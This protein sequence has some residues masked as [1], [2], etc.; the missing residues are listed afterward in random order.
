ME[1]RPLV[2]ILVTKRN[3][4][5]KTL[6]LYQKYHDLNLRLFAF[7]PADIQWKAQRIIGMTR[8]KDRWVERTFPFPNAVYNRSF[9]KKK[10]TVRRL[11]RSIGRNKC[12][13]A[14]NYFN[15][16]ELHDLLKQS[17]LHSYV[18]DTSLLNQENIL[19]MINKYRLVYIKPLYGSK[20]TSVHRVELK[21]NGDIHISLHSL[22]PKYIYRKEEHSRQRMEDL[23][24]GKKYV[25]Q[26]GIRMKPLNQCVF[27]IRVLVQKGRI[28]EWTV[29]AVTCRVAYEHYFN[30]SVCTAV[31][32]FEDVA[33]QFLS[34]EETNR[35]LR[36]LHE[37]S[38]AAAQAAEN[39][40]GSLGE[41]SVDFG[42]DEQH[43]LWIIELNGK[44]QKKIY[45]APSCVKYKKLIYKQ[46]LEYASY[47]SRQENDKSDDR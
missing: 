7:S 14:I 16:W 31:R 42:I 24:K 23:F 19:E 46:P 41:I 30:T 2:G 43:K 37:V 13:N 10:I 20:G 3:L 40:M 25:V 38:I 29:S 21:E 12:F 18:P 33:P 22:A 9:N 6:A 15:K 8:R 47:L 26:Q 35:I 17:A 44:P 5:K 36:S 27:D 34:S 4:R 1:N 32:D 39:R 45:N 11:E 28:G